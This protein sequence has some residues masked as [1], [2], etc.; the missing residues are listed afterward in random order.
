VGLGIALA[1]QGTP[2]GVLFGLLFVGLG[3][4]TWILTSF[5]LRYWYDVPPNLRHFVVGPGA[6]LGF[7]VA[8]VFIGGTLLVSRAIIFATR[9]L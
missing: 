5:G 6:V 7:L 8:A 4:A 2:A 9:V 1:V 3:L